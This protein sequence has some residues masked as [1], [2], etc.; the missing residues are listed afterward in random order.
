[1]MNVVAILAMVVAATE[2]GGM[3]GMGMGMPM[4]GMGMFPGMGKMGMMGHPMMHQHEE[5]APNML[6]CQLN[7]RDVNDPSIITNSISINIKEKAKSGSSMS[8][9]GG[10][11]MGHMNMNLMNHGT[12]ANKGEL[13]ADIGIFFHHGRESHHW[14]HRNRPTTRRMCC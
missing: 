7:F 13:E 12:D 11:G 10:M 5:E 6:T 4:G 3:M 8:G 9:Y 1:M 14:T 2:A